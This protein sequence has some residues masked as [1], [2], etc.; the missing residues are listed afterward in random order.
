M[1]FTD[2]VNY[3]GEYLNPAIVNKSVALSSTATTTWNA[4]AEL[5]NASGTIIATSSQISFSVTPNTTTTIVY[6][7]STSLTA[8]TTPFLIATSTCSGWADITCEMGNWST[9]VF[10]FLFGIDENTIQSIAGFSFATQAPFNIIPDIQNDFANIDTSNQSIASSSISFSLGGDTK[11]VTFFSQA[12]IE[13]FMG[14]DFISFIRN[15]ILAILT[16]AMF[17]GWYIEIKNIFRPK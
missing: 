3:Y 16:I 13:E 15:L 12:T 7:T 14:N 8:T 2:Q 4:I 11:N 17:F 5:L 9:G 10:N 1:P 6:P